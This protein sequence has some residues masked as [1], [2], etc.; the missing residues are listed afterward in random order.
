M[1]QENTPRKILENFYGLTSNVMNIITAEDVAHDNDVFRRTMGGK[2]NGRVVFT[3]GASEPY[4]LQL[5][6]QVFVAQDTKFTEDNDPYG[7][8]DFGTVEFRNEKY[9]WKIDYLDAENTEYGGD[10]YTQ[11][12]YRVLTIMRADEY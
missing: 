4:E 8:H 10:P 7:E 12:V 9:F 3:P 5:L 6:L 1:P 11:A 2:G